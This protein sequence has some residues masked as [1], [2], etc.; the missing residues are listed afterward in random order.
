MGLNSNLPRSQVFIS[1]AGADS[2]RASS[3][4]SMLS[5]AG[6]DTR[7]DR[8][9][10]SLGDSFLSFMEEALQT[11][12]Y[13][14]LLWSQ[15]AASSPWVTMEWESALVRSVRE[16]RGFL[17]LGRLEDVATPALLAPRLWVDLFPE[18]EPGVRQVLE[19][20]KRDRDAENVS[21][22]PVGSPTSPP[23]NV[24]NGRSVYVTSELFGVAVPMTLSPTQPAAALVEELVSHFE[25]PRLWQHDGRIGVKFSYSF[26]HGLQRLPPTSTLADAGVPENAV[27]TLLAKMNPFAAEPAAEGKLTSAAFRSALGD[28]P[29]AMS[30]SEVAARAMLRSAIRQ[31]G[32]A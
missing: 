32:L 24:E 26:E 4:A 12:S 2:D 7:F 3:V 28:T 21:M 10:L 23:P 19:T 9:R 15:A 17:L 29:R 14:L 5:A 30:N 27:L 11:S 8:E 18:L 25:L 20:W 22:K 6:V 31:A 1:H 13:C 16:K